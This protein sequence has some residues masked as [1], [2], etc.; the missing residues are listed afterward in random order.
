MYILYI[1]IEPTRNTPSFIKEGAFSWFK[2]YFVF[3]SGKCRMI[4]IITGMGPA[5]VQ[6]FI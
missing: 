4:L 3:Y 1:A 6:H 5:H 2:P